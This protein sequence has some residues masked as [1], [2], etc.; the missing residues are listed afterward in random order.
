MVKEPSLLQRTFWRPFLMV[1][2]KV[3]RHVL[4]LQ[5]SAIGQLQ[6]NFRSV[7]RHMAAKMVAMF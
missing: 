3:P 7:M 1:Q 6:L 2:M 5:I 4:C